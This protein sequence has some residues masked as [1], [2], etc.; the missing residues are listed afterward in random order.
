MLELIAN[1]YCPIKLY[2]TNR[3]NISLPCSLKQHCYIAD[4]KYF[5]A[6]QHFLAAEQR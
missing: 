2:I 3:I 4:Y 1:H 5:A 6:L